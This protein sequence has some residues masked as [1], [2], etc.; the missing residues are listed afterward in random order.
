MIENSFKSSLNG[1]D[2]EVFYSYKDKNKVKLFFIHDGEILG[3]IENN[4]INKLDDSTDNIILVSIYSKNRLDDYTPWKENKHRSDFPFGG[5]GNEYIR[6]IVEDL[7]KEIQRKL[8]IKIPA[9]RTFIGG[10]S[11]G[12]LISLYAI[13]EYENEFG[14]AILVSSSFWYDNFIDYLVEKRNINQNLLIYMDVGNK[15]G[16]GKITL[17]R[18]VLPLTKEVYNILLDKGVKK[19]NIKFL[20]KDKMAHRSTY[21][22][23]RLYDGIKYIYDN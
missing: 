19:E 22:I 3:K 2:Y 13:L 12:G 5:N 9:N 14:G 7:K 8:N 17:N 15:E 10:A 23:D 20:I 4:I 11:L 21:F 1:Y 16:K 18:D 6:F